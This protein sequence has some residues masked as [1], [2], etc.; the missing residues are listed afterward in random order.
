MKIL[1]QY[2]TQDDYDEWKEPVDV[3]EVVEVVEFG[4]ILRDKYGMVWGVKDE[5]GDWVSPTLRKYGIRAK[6]KVIQERD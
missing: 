2:D 6:L 4:D 1:G 3:V 5:Y